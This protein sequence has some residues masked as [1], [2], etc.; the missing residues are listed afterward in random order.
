MCP[1]VEHVEEVGVTGEKNLSLSNHFSCGSVVE[2]P[3]PMTVSV[4]SVEVDDSDGCDDL[5]LPPRT[6][7]HRPACPTTHS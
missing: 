4:V 6:V 1:Q 2:D 5:G 3:T 7:K